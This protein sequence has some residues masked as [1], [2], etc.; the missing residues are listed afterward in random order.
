MP[1]EMASVLRITGT[2]T[3]PAM[4]RVD[5]RITITSSLLRAYPKTH[6]RAIWRKASTR[7]SDRHS[8]EIPER[9]RGRYENSML[10]PSEP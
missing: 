9:R 5:E 6:P 4:L 8:I 1:A 10:V 7:F 2:E 3:I